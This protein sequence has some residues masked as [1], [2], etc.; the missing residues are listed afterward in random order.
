[1]AYNPAYLNNNS[2]DETV[3][4]A[5][6]IAVGNEEVS[7]LTL[8]DIIDAGSKDGGALANKKEQFTKALI[9]MWAKNMF[10]DTEFQTDE[11]DPFFV[12][13][14]EYGAIIQMISAQAPSV[15]ES[16]AWKEFISGSSQVGVYTVYLPIVDTKYYGKTTSWGLPIAIS[17]EQYKDAF[18]D[19]DGFN[20][21]RAYIQ[22]VVKNA[23]K[24]H[25]K[26]MNNANR[27]NFIAEK[28]LY[29]SRPVTAGKYEVTITTA[30]AATDQ[31][32]L[33]GTTLKWVAS[34]PG[35]GEIALPGTNNAAN[36]A[37]A[38]VTALNA[39]T[40][41]T[42]AGGWTWTNT[43]AKLIATQKS[44]APKAVFSA[45]V[46]E[47]ATM[48]LGTVNVVTESHNPTG[49]HLFHLLTEYNSEMNGNIAS[50][51]EFMRT[52]ECLRYMDRKIAEYAGYMT[53]QTVLFNTDEKVKFTPRERLVL[54]VLGYAEQAV[55]SILM[56]DTFHNE[57]VSLPGYRRVSAWQGLG[58][59]DSVAFGD[60]SKINV[61]VADGTSDGANVELNNVVA[62]LADKWAILHTIRDERVGVQNYDIEALSLFEYQ[63]RDQYM[64]NLTQNAVVFVVD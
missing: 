54:E 1:M 60:I 28:K 59:G 61:N 22:T 21:F 33:A 52:K 31:V 13:S 62:F 58:N 5:Y 16:H 56:S 51:A 50:A 30:A 12:D 41:K 46:S 23:I 32:T 20:S 19:A 44:D 43:G 29:T 15:Q 57:F 63:F 35:A 36:E 53:E 39:V 37:S 25:R 10:L 7:K 34:N 6:D 9:S 48:V 11:D 4:A 18:R 47:G 45:S 8:K 26:D 55:N 17:Y 64:N 3:N 2:V 40:D 42:K 38:L 27:N 49:T 14:R 24:Q